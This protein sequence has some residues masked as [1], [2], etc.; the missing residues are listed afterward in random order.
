MGLDAFGNIYATA[1]SASLRRQEV[2]K[3]G[4]VTLSN[5]YSFLAKYDPAGNALWAIAP[6]GTNIA[7]PWGLELVDH[8]EIYLAGQFRSFASFGQFKLI[9]T[10]P[11]GSGAFYVAKFAADTSATVTLGLPQLVAG[12]TQIQFSVAGVAGC[13]YAVEGSTDLIHW[14]PLSTN[15]SP[16][17]YSEPIS[18]L[19]LTRF[20]RT[21]Y[22]P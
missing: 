5:T 13:K 21:A 22:R 15:T 4:S 7:I 2:L 19:G 8:H 18:S 17:V 6:G 16:F 9:D 3:F 11:T 12:G 14:A 10:N 20:Y 1:A